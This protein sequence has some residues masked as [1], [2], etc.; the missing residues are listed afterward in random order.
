LADAAMPDPSPEQ[1]AQPPVIETQS[2][3]DVDMC[4]DAGV[5]A[6]VVRGRIT[7]LDPAMQARFRIRLAE[8]PS[9]YEAITGTDGLFEVRIPRRE[10]GVT[11]LCTLPLHGQH[12]AAAFAGSHM[13][14]Q[15]K[16][17]FEH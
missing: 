7:S 6:I 4:S 5:T 11:D 13:T 8:V 9:R 2:L 16:L 12:P 10:L 1:L 3:T 15:Y 17:Y 14:V